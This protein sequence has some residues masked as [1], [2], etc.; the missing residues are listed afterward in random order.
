MET[1]G[2]GSPGGHAACR[3]GWATSRDSGS[4]TTRDRSLKAPPVWAAE[5][6]SSPVETS[7]VQVGGRVG[8]AE[9][10]G[11]TGGLVG[12]QTDGGMV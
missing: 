10:C 4:A 5:W 9:G 6:N 7:S 8:W 11:W 1:G 12:G 3:A 2:A